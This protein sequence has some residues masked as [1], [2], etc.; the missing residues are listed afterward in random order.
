MQVGL[1]DEVGDGDADGAEK[2]S[3]ALIP[4]VAVEPLMWQTAPLCMTIPPPSGNDS[5][6]WLRQLFPTV[7]A[8][9]TFNLYRELYWKR[10]AGGAD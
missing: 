7:F 4:R 8:S 5:W 10:P 9:R 2:R 3:E 1:A 6:R